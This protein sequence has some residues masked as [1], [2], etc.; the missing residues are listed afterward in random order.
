MKDITAN[1]LYEGFLGHGLFAEQLPPIFTSEAFMKYAKQKYPNVIS[2]QGY[3]W[4]SVDIIRNTTVPRTLG[5][6]NPFAYHNLCWKLKEKWGAIQE[7]LVKN[8]KSWKQN[9]VSRVHIRKM[10]ETN[11]LFR[12]NYHNWRI[13]GNPKMNWRIGSKYV[14]IA[15]I[16]SCF[17]S[18]Y[19]H[20]LPWAL[21]GKEK[22]KSLYRTNKSVD[23]QSVDYQEYQ[24]WNELDAFVRY[25]QNNETHG[26]LIGPHASNV[27]SEIILTKI[28]S[29][30]SNWHYE[31]S[32]DDYVCYVSS[33]EEAEAFLGDLIQQLRI[34]DL[35][36]NH[37]KTKIEV[38]PEEKSISK[39]DK[40]K[41]VEVMLFPQKEYEE[42]KG[43]KK[44][45]KIAK[46][47]KIRYLDYE[48][49]KKYLEQSI[50]IACKD[51]VDI[52]PI[53]Y[54]IKV[55][56]NKE[57]FKLSREAKAY[58]YRTSLYLA[59]LYP[60]LLR[61]LDGSVLRTNSREKVCKRILVQ[62]AI[63]HAKA[64]NQF[65]EAYYAI[66]FDIEYQLNSVK[67]DELTGYVQWIIHSDDCL[68]KLFGWLWCRYYQQNELI[69]AFTKE[70]MRLATNGEWDKNWLFAYEC[71]KENDLDMLR[72]QQP[73]PYKLVDEWY[74]LKKNK[75]SFLRDSWKGD[76]KAK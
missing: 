43:K 35:T 5:I 20:A 25:T 21:M 56:G 2:K 34:Y 26:I 9:K 50:Y 58:F 71:L 29:A 47:L 32:I 18:I 68:L 62:K 41:L 11:A 54:A 16:S 36:L 13:D 7:K 48:H 1:E 46:K 63:Q 28:D 60:Y 17:P 4:I 6:P 66:L 33:Y 59:G 19:T 45:G 76:A 10:K 30:L 42:D 23:K 15:D 75:I 72:K 27:L 31:R 69:E 53:N 24:S 3:E 8:T 38:L 37:K 67:I 74:N 65:E 73:Y 40:L 12:M 14:V 57:Q 49:V 64:S 61:M 51:E 52:A 22:A 70:A 39:Y 55:L 44:K